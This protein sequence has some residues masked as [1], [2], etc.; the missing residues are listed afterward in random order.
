MLYNKASAIPVMLQFHESVTISQNSVCLT[1][2]HDP[3]RQENLH[4]MIEIENCIPDHIESM[5]VD[6]V[7]SMELTSSLSSAHQG[8]E[9]EPVRIIT[10]SV[11]PKRFFK[12]FW[13]SAARR[14]LERADMMPTDSRKLNF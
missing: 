12:F 4:Y 7:E 6:C 11:P 9:Y 14:M 8:V 1:A 3:A 2:S 13:R 5:Q 10:C